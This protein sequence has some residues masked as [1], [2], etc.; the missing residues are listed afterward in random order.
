MVV[1]LK[2]YVE[3]MLR[4]DTQGFYRGYVGQYRGLMNCLE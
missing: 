4:R 1:P 2:G 3:M